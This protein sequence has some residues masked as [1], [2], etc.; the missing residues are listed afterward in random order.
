MVCYKLLIVT[1]SRTHT[2]T[3]GIVAYLRVSTDEQAASGLGL[4]A[5]RASIAA[6]AER[7]G[8]PIVATFVDAGLS[9][10]NLS[11]PGLAQA[12]RSVESGN[13]TVL[14]VAKLD[15]LSRS[16]HDAT[17]LLEQS[18]RGGW[19]LVALDVA[20][21]TTTPAGTAMTHI[22]SV[23]AELERR[24]IGERTKA[25]LTAKK[26]RGDKLGRPRV[27]SVAVEARIRRD[28]D[29]GM[30]WSA[31]ARALNAEEV[32]TA[33]GGRWHPATVRLIATR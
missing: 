23:F 32:P 1:R 26:A 12:L 8:L 17:G 5:Q 21:D 16:V 4:D 31:I 3:P 10:K 9:G 29:A 24:L 6:E 2:A 19:G 30:S 7:R 14:C 20:V 13:G 11:R 22:L 27:I 28:H 18:T 25:A 15:R 33:Q